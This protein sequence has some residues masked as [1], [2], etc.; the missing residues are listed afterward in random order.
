MNTKFNKVERSFEDHI[1]KFQRYNT[2]YAKKIEDLHEENSKR[3]KCA[4]L[5][6]NYGNPRAKFG[7][8]QIQ[9]T[10]NKGH[11]N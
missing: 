5:K 9:Q 1:I 4:D 3:E 2:D 6:Q 7:G 10:D 11:L 8:M